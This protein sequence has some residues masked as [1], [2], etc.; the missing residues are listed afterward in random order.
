MSTKPVT[1]EDLKRLQHA[2]NRINAA[3]EEME[4]AKQHIDMIN[5]I[6]DLKYGLKEGDQIAPDGVIIKAKKKEVEKPAPH[7][8][9]G[10]KARKR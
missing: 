7:K 5:E 8:K 3:G 9:R 1:E 4:A 2:Q 10:K 6:M